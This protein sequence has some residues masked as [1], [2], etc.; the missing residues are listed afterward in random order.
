M[1]HAAATARGQPAVLSPA[2]LAAYSSALS[3]RSVAAR[4][5]LAADLTGDAAEAGFWRRLPATLDA[6]RGALEAGSTAAPVTAGP[7]HAAPAA[8][9]GGP[10]LLWEQGVE[11]AEAVERSNWHEQMSRRIFEDSEDLQ[12][13]L[14]RGCPLAVRSHFTCKLGVALLQGCGDFKR[15]LPNVAWALLCT[16]RLAP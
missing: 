16:R 5:A 4:M 8:A 15:A 14:A 12:A 7:R 13:C 3:T 10:R 6:V 2:E 9:A 11:M 1:L